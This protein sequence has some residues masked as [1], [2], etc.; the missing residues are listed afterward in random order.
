[1]V[2]VKTVESFYK[3]VGKGTCP[4]IDTDFESIRRDDVKK[5][6]E[7]KYGADR[8]CSLGAYTSLQMRAVFRDFCKLRNVPQA[9]V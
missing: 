6:M 5:Y 7:S 4:D 1:M 3:K 9:T 8:V 2:Q